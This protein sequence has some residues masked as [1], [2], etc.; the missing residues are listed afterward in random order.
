MGDD[1]AQKDTLWLNAALA[2][3]GVAVLVLAYSF[4]AR[5]FSP[6]VDPVREANPASLVGEIIQVEVRN[7]AGVNG[8]AARAT[9]YLRDHGFDVVEVGN[10]KAGG[11]D[12]SMV[13]DRVGDHAA[14]VKVANALGIGEDRVVE[15]IKADFFL[16]ASVVIGKDYATLK[17]FLEE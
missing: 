7:G 13:I 12:H 10:Y 11:V 14:A 2:I 5:T 9:D 6:R 16:D 17:P 8:L 15:E 4:I 1:Q 3:L